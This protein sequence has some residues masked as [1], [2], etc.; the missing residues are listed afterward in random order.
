MGLEGFLLGLKN[1]WA[2]FLL[3]LSLKKKRS[4]GSPEEIFGSVFSA[5]VFCTKIFTDHNNFGKF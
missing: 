4:G 3:F 2:A 1:N 5:D